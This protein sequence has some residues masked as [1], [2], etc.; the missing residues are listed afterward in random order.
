MGGHVAEM[1]RREMPEG[2]RPLRKPER[3]WVDNANVDLGTI[4]WDGVN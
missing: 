4:E 1:W 2:K 3:R